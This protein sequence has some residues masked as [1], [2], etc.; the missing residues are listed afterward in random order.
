MSVQQQVVY[1]GSWAARATSTGSPAYAYKSLASPTSELYYDGR[2]QAISQGTANVSIV[3]FRTPT[4]DPLVS[5]YRLGNG[6]LSYY[7][8][9]TGVTTSG[10]PSRPEAGTSS[11][12]TC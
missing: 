12:C 11:R 1:A 10:P 7:N 2:F 9:I 8:P 3:R 4:N 6:K 5:I